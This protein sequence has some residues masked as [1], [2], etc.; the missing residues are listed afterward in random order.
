MTLIIDTIALVTIFVIAI[1]RLN[2]RKHNFYRTVFWAM[3]AAGSVGVAGEQL[4]K[5]VVVGRAVVFGPDL[6]VV[7]QHIGVAGLL[8]GYFCCWRWTDRRRHDMAHMPERR[9]A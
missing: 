8:A 6:W 3:I 2:E 1:M 9:V 4:A 5:S 7:M